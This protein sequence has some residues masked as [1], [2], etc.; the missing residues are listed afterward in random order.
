MAF[1]LLDGEIS[2]PGIILLHEKSGIVIDASL[3]YANG[4]FVRINREH[5]PEVTLEQLAEA[6]H[7]DEEQ[8]FN[9]LG[10]EGIL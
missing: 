10:L 9:V 2:F 6:L 3:A 1:K 8:L 7:K 4:L 5:P